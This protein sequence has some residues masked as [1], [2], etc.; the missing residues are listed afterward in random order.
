MR[1][2]KAALNY[3]DEWVWLVIWLTGSAFVVIAVAGGASL[4]EI[5][6]LVVLTV[7]AAMRWAVTSNVWDWLHGREP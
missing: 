4:V 5:G 7:Y 6:L 3:I 2:V 1:W